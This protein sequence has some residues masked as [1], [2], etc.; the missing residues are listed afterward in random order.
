MS[1]Q[2]IC[3]NFTFPVF[4][5]LLSCFFPALAQEPSAEKK[6]AR[7]MI[8]VI[9]SQPVEG[10]TDLKLVQGDVLRK[11]LA[12]IPSLV[13]DPIEIGRGELALAKYSGSGKELVLNPL[14]KVT[15]PEA[16]TR[17]VL[18]I[19]PSPDAKPE[20]PYRHLLIR[21]DDLNFKA[22]DLYLFNLTSA[23]IGGELGKSKF[24]V[25]PAKSSI[26]TPAPE[27]ATER[28][29]QARF[30]SQSEGVPRIFNDT[31]WPLATTAR[32]YL[33]FIP[34]PARQSIGYV[35]FREY[36]PFP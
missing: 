21:T 29:Y 18:A 7:I 10:A 36:S 6:E 34:D 1:H 27:S 15:I 19:F 22:S 32:V 17:F 4:L 12:I 28:M 5:A 13:T 23:P 31:R 26:V 33:F 3:H 30:Y 8:R 25:A 20:M 35:S 14:V 16:G 11:D 24:L 2:R 9:C